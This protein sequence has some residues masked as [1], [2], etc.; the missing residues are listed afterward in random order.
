MVISSLMYTFR[1][2]FCNTKLQYS[3]SRNYW[4]FSRIGSHFGFECFTNPVLRTFKM[5]RNHLRTFHKYFF[6][7]CNRNRF[8][9]FYLEGHHI[10]RQK[11]WILKHFPNKSVKDFKY[12]FIRT[13]SGAP[14]WP[15]MS[16]F[17]LSNDVFTPYYNYYW[18]VTYCYFLFHSKQL[19]IR[20]CC[21]LFERTRM[22]IANGCCQGP[23]EPQPP[24][25][26][27]HYRLQYSLVI[28]ILSSAR[29]S[30]LPK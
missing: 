21:V 9:L 1:I 12:S 24:V 7:C 11:M 18:I 29:S 26:Q 5:N 30:Y 27:P 17:H 10:P 25:R 6:H 22:V 13:H 3:D 19:H 15:T 16:N 4:H 2:S 23:S 8:T 14:K 28:R 20:C